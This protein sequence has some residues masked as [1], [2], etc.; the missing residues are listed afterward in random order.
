MARR[1]TKKSSPSFS[2]NLLSGNADFIESLPA[3]LTKESDV[4]EIERATY[5]PEYVP[6]SLSAESDLDESSSSEVVT[7]PVW[8][9]IDGNGSDNFDDVAGLT[10]LLK[11]GTEY[12]LECEWDKV[13]PS[14]KPAPSKNMVN[15]FGV[16]LYINGKKYSFSHNEQGVGIANLTHPPVPAETETISTILS[17]SSEIEVL[18]K[19][20]LKV[21]WGE[22]SDDS[23][24]ED[25][26]DIKGDPETTFCVV[27]FSVKEADGSI[28]PI[29]SFTVDKG[30]SY[31]DFKNEPDVNYILENTPARG[32][33]IWVFTG[34]SED[35][36]GDGNINESITS[37]AQYEPAE[38]FVPFDFNGATNESEI[39][40]EDSP[41]QK[42]EDLPYMK[43]KWGDK[44][45]KIIPPPKNGDLLSAGVFLK[46]NDEQLVIQKTHLSDGSATSLAKSVYFGSQTVTVGDP[47]IKI[48]SCKLIVAWSTPINKSTQKDI[49]EAIGIIPTPFASDASATISIPKKDALDGTTVS[50]EDGFPSS[51]TKPLIK[52]TGEV[53]TTARVI[54][55]RQVNT[56]GYI[57]T[58]EQFFEQC[59]GYHTFDTEICNA[60][61]G[62]PKGAI[63]KFY[64]ESTNSLRTVYSLLDDN[65]WN[66]IENGVDGIHW[67][68][69]DD[70]PVLN[71]K[72]D[73]SD[74]I[75]LRDVLFVETG[76]PDFYEIPHDGFLQLYAL[77]Y[78]DMHSTERDINKEYAIERVSITQHEEL[79]GDRIYYIADPV[80]EN[81]QGAL[82]TK[83]YGETFLD[84][85]NEKT[86]TTNSFYVRLDASNSVRVSVWQATH[87][88]PLGAYYMYNIPQYV[89]T[90]G[91][92]FLNK[93]DKIRIRGSYT[94]K[95][96]PDAIGDASRVY[97]RVLSDNEV[98]RNYIKKFANFYRVGWEG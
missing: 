53:D 46:T 5:F 91:S 54:T 33:G 58:Q 18:T 7:G 84:V 55:R 73:Y 63:L 60:I 24:E 37:W 8:I 30:T 21:F 85:Y 86:N 71:L 80:Y 1:K 36:S 89:V 82:E 97:D 2:E 78:C 92:F 14:L 95:V 57:G 10:P 23:S 74:F 69:I 61:G 9:R 67:K 70:L 88:G 13:F 17:T 49:R 45:P 32:S 47:D 83:F 56:L 15:A 29:G 90:Q 20:Y 41:I 75:D 94:D 64:Q 31:S 44:Y 50:F 22:E 62:Y 76:I 3:S 66:F 34:W 27:N 72:V 79:R 16:I 59:G 40:V 51:Y 43:C 93:G 48:G 87:Y 26:L 52:P 4:E 6:S 38:F 98:R 42:I 35:F 28:T 11:I 39:I 81:V 96:F 19:A 12:Y 68:Y 77:S 65:D 25:S